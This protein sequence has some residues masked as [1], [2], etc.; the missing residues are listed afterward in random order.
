[1]IRVEFAIS[2]AELAQGITAALIAALA[3]VLAVLVRRRRARER[4]DRLLIG[5]KHDFFPPAEHSAI[6]EI[7]REVDASHRRYERQLLEEDWKRG[8]CVTLEK[9]KGA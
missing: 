3:V 9:R 4:A 6:E 7:R 2:Y 1:M 8:G 5:I